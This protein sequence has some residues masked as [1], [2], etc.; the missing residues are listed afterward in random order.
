MSDPIYMQMSRSGDPQKL[1][2]AHRVALLQ[3]IPLF[4]GVSKRHLRHLAKLTRIEQF[5]ADQDLLVEGQASTVAFV[6]IAGTVVVRRKGR[7]IAELGPG[8][9]VGELG[10]LLERPRAATVRS[11]TP[12][13]CLALDR[14][15]LKAAVVELPRLGW[16]LLE[17]VATRL[18]D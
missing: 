18:S 4:D 16:D 14:R 3:E 1:A 15:A 12:V 8:Q 17:T 11:I 5:G 13:E 2:Q 6:L 7:K 10:L 9:V